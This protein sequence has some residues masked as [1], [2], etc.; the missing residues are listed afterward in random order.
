MTS[1]RASRI[2]NDHQIDYSPF[3]PVSVKG[4]C[5]DSSTFSI[6]YFVDS[7]ATNLKGSESNLH[8][9][10]SF[11]VDSVSKRFYGLVAYVF[12]DKQKSWF[13]KRLLYVDSPYIKVLLRHELFHYFLYVAQMKEL[14]NIYKKEKNATESKATVL[15]DKYHAIFKG[16]Q[17]EYDN[18]HG[19]DGIDLI[20]QKKWE[21]D[22]IKRLNRVEN[23]KIAC[24][25]LY[26]FY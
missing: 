17:S 16:E 19:H 20:H 22:V 4:E 26:T 25:L 21:Q 15:W 11:K 5:L 1:C 3:L 2:A 23:I 12:F 8:I 13:N 14:V 9:G 6:D 10:I 24:D 18:Q 7:A